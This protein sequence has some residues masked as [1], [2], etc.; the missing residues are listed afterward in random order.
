MD[1]IVGTFKYNKE[2]EGVVQN[3]EGKRYVRLHSGLIPNKAWRRK[4]LFVCNILVSW[5]MSWKS[6]WQPGK[7]LDGQVAGRERED[8]CAWH[9]APS[10]SR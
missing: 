5:K 7:S 10:D 8:G 1:L 6:Y 2:E 9:L 4:M 3:L